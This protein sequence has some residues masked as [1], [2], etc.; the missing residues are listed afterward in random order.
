MPDVALGVAAILGAV[1]AVFQWPLQVRTVLLA[2]ER[3]VREVLRV[4]AGPAPS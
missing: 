2:V 3:H 4:A 1:D